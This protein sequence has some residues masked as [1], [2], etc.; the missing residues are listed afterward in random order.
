MV[1][2]IYIIDLKDGMITVC[3]ILNEKGDYANRKDTLALARNLYLPVVCL[4]E[5]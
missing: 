4:S 3:D 1:R 5:F 2:L